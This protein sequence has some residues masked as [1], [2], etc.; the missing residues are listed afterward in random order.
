MN[1]TTGQS[2]AKPN[3]TSAS[4][5]DS[6]PPSKNQKKNEPAANS[7]FGTGSNGGTET[8]REHFGTTHTHD[9]KSHDSEQQA[10]FAPKRMNPRENGLRRSPRLKEQR[11]KAEA[12][13]RKAHV[14]F[15]TAAATKIVFGLLAMF[16]LTSNFTMP[17]HTNTPAA[18]FTEAAMNRFHE[19]NELYDGTLNT[20]HHML[21]S[22]DIS[23]NECFTFH[24]AMKQDDKLQFV[25]AMEKE[26]GDHESRNHWSIVHRDTLPS[27]AKPIKAIW[28]FKRKRK[29]DGELLKHKARLCAHGGMQQWGDSY[30]ETYSPVVNMLSVR[31]ILAIAK[32]HKLD[33]K[34][35]DFVLAFP[36]AEL[37]EDIWMLLPIGFQVDGMTEA[38]SERQYLLKLNANLYGLKQ[39]SYNWYE[40]LKAALI[41]RGLNPSDIDPC[42]YIGNGMIVLTYVDDCIIVGPSMKNIDAFVK[43]MKEGS[44]NF[45][46]TD[47]GDIDKFLGIEITQLEDGKR[48]KIAQ[49]HLINRIISFLNIDTNDYG[50]DTNSKSTPVGK[51]LLH[52]DLSGKQRKETW[53]Y[54]T[55]VG[56][57]TYLQGNTRPEIAMAVHQTARFCN[58][59]KLSHEKA[60]KRL[61]RYLYHTKNEGIIYNP[62]VKKGLECFVDADFAGGWTQADADDADNVLSRTGMV[63]MYAGCPIF[64]RS[65]LQTEIA[66]STAE[67]EYIALSS[68]LRE[69]LPLMTMM[70]E[71]NKVFKLH[72]NT[73]KFVCTVHE[74]NQSCIKMATGTK[75]T[76]RTKHIALKY[77]HFKT[78]VKSGR[79]DIKYKPTH[80]QLADLLTKPL[81]NEAFFTLRY[82]L[83]GWGYHPGR[84]G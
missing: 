16:A 41:D 42:L 2:S 6:S 50:M 31:L 10:M 60:I 35:I 46:L 24:Q 52:K 49:P 23:S 22:S 74:D 38:E 78:H 29:P 79:V 83:C 53:N 47:E 27:N 15:G 64:W 73:P 8:Q 34:A 37:D 55:A 77:H 72:I 36:Q 51:P 44:E 67:A 13:K 5:G 61:G 69:V 68:A 70:E 17:N 45:I 84:I 26:I 65:S 56:M 3:L 20:V 30:W 58:N 32:I 63:I 4:E 9:T 21:Y 28:S 43:S 48:F 25:E 14:T 81:P 12:N 33:S 71:I 18:T 62:D 66:L 1:N 40:K 75:F 57:L 39:A 82:M 54:R 80:E 19:V 76:P 11:E 7:F 59:P